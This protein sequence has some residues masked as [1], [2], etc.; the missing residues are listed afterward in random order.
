M[1][2]SAI[3]PLD[4]MKQSLL[5]KTM[6]DENKKMSLNNDENGRSLMAISI[7]VKYSI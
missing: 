5:S 3:V 4:E 1:H 6:F 7:D 2:V